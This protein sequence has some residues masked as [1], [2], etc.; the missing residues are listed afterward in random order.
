MP[1]TL[2]VL[3]SH[4]ISRDDLT[5]ALHVLPQ[6]RPPRKAKRKRERQDAILAKIPGDTSYSVDA[7]FAV[8]VS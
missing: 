8:L 3:L 7:K 4:L 5:P 2:M 1:E 6:K